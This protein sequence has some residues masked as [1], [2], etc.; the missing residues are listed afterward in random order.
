MEIDRPET[1]DVDAIV[2]LW[3]AL[4]DDQRAHGS[5]VRGRESEATIRQSIAQRVV[6]DRAFVARSEEEGIVGFV[7]F[8]LE[9][10]TYRRDVSRGVVENLYVEP[11][12]RDRGV[13]SALLERAERTLADHGAD[14]VTLE[15][16]AEN[17]DARRFYERAGYHVHRVEFEKPVGNDTH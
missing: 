7:T 14:V 2:E 4:A 16:M 13:G 12:H 17:D 9:E 8:G 1:T 15:A 11:G 10:D 6:G 3:V 5:H